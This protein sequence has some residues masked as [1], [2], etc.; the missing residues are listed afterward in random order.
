MLSLLLLASSL[1][2]VPVGPP[3]AALIAPPASWAPPLHWLEGG[4]S[5]CASVSPVF[6]AEPSPTAQTSEALRA[7]D[8]SATVVVDTRALR[9]W[10]VRSPPQVLAALPGLVPVLHDLPSTGS[11]LRV[12]LGVVCNGERQAR[13]GLGALEW[14]SAHPGCLPDFWYRP[15]LK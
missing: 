15:R 14:V 12:P 3:A 1:S 11:R 9:L 4:V 10:R 7:L 2:Q 8:P 13:P 6:V 5:R